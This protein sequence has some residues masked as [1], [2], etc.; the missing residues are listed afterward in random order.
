MGAPPNA[1]FAAFISYHQ[2]SDGAFARQLQ[3]DLERFGK[4]IWKPRM[5]R[6]FRDETNLALQRQ[7]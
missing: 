3:T 6:L 2:S 1:R 4:P 5:V 7:I